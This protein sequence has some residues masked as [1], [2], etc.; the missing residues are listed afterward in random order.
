MPDQIGSIH[1]WNWTSHLALECASHSVRLRSRHSNRTSPWK[2]E[3]LHGSFKVYISFTQLTATAVPHISVICSYD[4][5]T[6]KQNLKVPEI[7]PQDKLYK[8]GS[9]A[10]FCCIMPAGE[11]FYKMYLIGYNSGSD[12]HINKISNQTFTLSVQLNQASSSSGIDVI[13]ETSKPETGACTYIGCKYD[14]ILCRIFGLWGY[15]YV[16]LINTFF[17]PF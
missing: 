13:C 12:M 6:G 4:V 2:E 9:K 8:V 5:F 14:L 1:S 17:C 3:T 16:L 15:N 10:V 11:I 7:F